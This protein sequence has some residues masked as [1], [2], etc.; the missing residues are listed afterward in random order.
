MTLTITESFEMLEEDDL[1]IFEEKLGSNLPQ[2]YRQFLLAHN[3]GKPNPS[4]VDYQKSN[5][6]PMSNTIIDYFFG[7]RLGDDYDLYDNLDT[8]VNCHRIPK[9][10]L[11]IAC[12]PFGNIFCI[13]LE[14]ADIGKVYLWHHEYEVDVGKGEV[15]DDSNVFFIAD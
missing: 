8:Y 14:G 10:L 9:N 4:I 11:P 7:I 1:R 3:G 13:S 5:L 15:A 12:S 6:E 2:E